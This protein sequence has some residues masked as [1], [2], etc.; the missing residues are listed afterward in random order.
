VNGWAIGLDEK[1]YLLH[2]R[3]Q[4]TALIG[5]NYL[6]METNVSNAPNKNKTDDGPALRFGAGLDV[7]ATNKFV[8]TTDVSYMLGLGQTDGY[9][10]VLVSL[11]F[12]FRP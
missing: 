8:L 2:G 9:D 1:V 11:G 6:N 12:L 5:L 7:Y 10:M 3:F 4:P